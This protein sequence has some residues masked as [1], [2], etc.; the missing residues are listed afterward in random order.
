ML[1]KIAAILLMICVLLVVLFEPKQEFAPIDV[2]REEVF[3]WRSVE[4]KYRI[5]EGDGELSISVK[6]DGTRVKQ[7]TAQAFGKTFQL[8]ASTQEQLTDYRLNTLDVTKN[9]PD[10]V[11]SGPS[12]HLRLDSKAKNPGNSI[13]LNITPDEDLQVYH[14]V[15]IVD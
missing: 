8:P 4:M 7:F 13:V 15:A 12:L 10:F 2:A 5:T 9:M 1:P 14:I 6:G 3:D 11:Y